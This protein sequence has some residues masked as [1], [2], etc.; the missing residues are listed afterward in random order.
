LIW[1]GRGIARKD[2]RVVAKIFFKIIYPMLG[3]RNVYFLSLMMKVLD[4]VY[5]LG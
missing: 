4:H 5:V 2:A 3:K 1:I